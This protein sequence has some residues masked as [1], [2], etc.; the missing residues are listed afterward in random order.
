MLTALLA[1]ALAAAPALPLEAVVA[2]ATIAGVSPSSP[3]WSPDGARLAF[4]W[5]DPAGGDRDVWLVE[6]SGDALHR[7]GAAGA[8][9]FA[10]APDG[11]AVFALV[12]GGELRRVPLAAGKVARLVPGS[13]ADRSELAVSPDGKLVSWLEG[14]DLWLVP[15]EGGEARRATSVGAPPPG[16]VAQGTYFRPD[17]EIGQGTWTGPG[18]SYRWS[19]DGRLVAVHA[20]DRRNVRKVPF[21]HYLFE[22]PILNWLRRP[23]PGDENEA[24]RVG[25]LEVATGKLD[26][27]DLPAPTSTL[28]NAMAWSP[29]GKLLVD[30]A[31]DTNVDR[32][33]HVF[34]PAAGALKE[35]WHDRRETRI[36]T[37]FG[38]AWAPGGDRVL[39]MADLDDR[40]GLYLLDLASGER[41]LLSPPTFDV[42]GYL[43]A[44]PATGDV[45]F[46]SNEPVPS[47]RQIWRLPAGGGA[48]VRVSARPGTHAAFP[49]PDGKAVALVSSDD[50]TPPELWLA[51]PAGGPA[52]RVTTSQPPAFAKVPWVKPRYASFPSRDGAYTLHV[53]VYEPRGVPK[54]KAAP[55]VLGPVYSNTVR[56]RWGGPWGILQQHLAIDRGFRVVQVDVRGSTGYGRAFREA[57]LMRWGQGDLDDLEDAVRWLGRQPGV[58]PGRI[59]IFG[60]SYGGTLTIYSLFKKPGL[61]AAGVAGAAAVDP[62]WFG[63]DDVAI[64]RTPGTHPDAFTKGAAIPYAAGLKDPLLIVHGMADDVVPFKTM[65]DLVEHLERS[66]KDFELAIGPSATHRWVAGPDA[67]YLVGR[68]VEFLE[69]NLKPARAR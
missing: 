37:E 49:A 36:Y 17:A 68:L 40:Y 39:V 33:L 7:V 35:V 15:A 55:T 5:K 26:W 67:R 62:R 52:R 20:V 28:V 21:P 64:A 4:L 8:T 32:W 18:A 13:G 43:A 2:P 23:A 57:F 9:A 16:A 3:A 53:R 56:N 31:S 48:R 38:S 27:L 61:F 30:R 19:P 47:E 44:V 22:E 46:A 66:G 41:T 59:G 12:A 25:I 34:D 58:D 65:V 6:R 10:W 60:S 42:E 45:Y 1:L 63:S 11:A 24:R 69:R 29:S 51:S 54:G 14:G 50:V